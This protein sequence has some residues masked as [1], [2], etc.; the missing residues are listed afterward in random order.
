MKG[1]DE[2]CTMEGAC[3]LEIG[4]EVV[5]GGVGKVGVP[6]WVQALNRGSQ[7]VRLRI[8]EV[9]HRPENSFK[10]SWKW[11]DFPEVGPPGCQRW[12]SGIRETGDRIPRRKP[13]SS[14]PHPEPGEMSFPRTQS[15][16]ID[17]L[18]HRGTEVRFLPVRSQ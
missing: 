9:S 3:V 8:P 11:T 6:E 1:K 14:P 18:H 17:V 5:F 2:K 4:V 10:K 7:G 13:I 15:R 16:Q 12:T